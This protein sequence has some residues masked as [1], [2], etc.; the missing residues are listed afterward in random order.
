M[1]AFM[2]LVNGQRGGAPLVE[3][4]ALDS[5]AR[6]RFE[7]ASSVYQISDYGFDNQ[8]ASYFNGTGK[9]ST[10]EILFPSY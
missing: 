10:E 9:I 5:F 2:Q 1:G 7:T 6:A 3:D 4:P 8:S